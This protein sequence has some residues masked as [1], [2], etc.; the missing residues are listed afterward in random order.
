FGGPSSPWPCDSSSKQ[1]QQALDIIYI[2]R[3]GVSVGTIA[4]SFGLP[5]DQVLPAKPLPS[6][7]G[8]RSISNTTYN[9]TAVHLAARLAI[10]WL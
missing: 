7:N 9:L 1:T 10:G 4:N 5:L 2:M 3:N 6:Q 8:T